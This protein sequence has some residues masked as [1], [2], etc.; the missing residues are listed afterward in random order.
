MTENLLAMK[1]KLM[2]EDWTIFVLNDHAK[3]SAKGFVQSPA[4]H[5]YF[6]LAPQ[7]GVLLLLKCSELG[8]F[9][10]I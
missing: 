10:I 9:T 8:Q 5:H 2:N 6:I 3:C 7:N 4:K 1:K